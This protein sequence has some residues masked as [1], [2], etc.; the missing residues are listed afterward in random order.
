MSRAESHVEPAS[1]PHESGPHERSIPRQVWRWSWRIVVILLGLVILAVGG[2]LIFLHTDSGRRVLRDQVNAQLDKM[3]VGGAHVGEIEGSPFST[4]IARDIVIND[5]TGKPFATVKKAEIEIGLYPLI[6]MHA[7]LRRVSL[8]DV[9]V[10]V[11]RGADGEFLATKL[12][13][14][15]DKKSSWNIDLS[16]LEVI[17]GHVAIEAGTSGPDHWVNLDGLGITARAHI[18]ADGPLDATVGLV[19]SWRE[20]VAPIQLQATVHDSAEGTTI[21]SLI[22]LV[23]GVSVAAGNLSILPAEPTPGHPSPLPRISGSITVSAPVL[24]LKQLIPSVEL[25]DDVLVTVTAQ[26][27]APWTRLAVVGTL[28]TQPIQLYASADFA[29]MHAIGTVMANGVDVTRWSQGTVVGTGGAVVSFDAALGREGE[30]P[31]ATGL[32][33]AWGDVMN[34]PHSMVAATY[35]TDF[36]HISTLAGVAGGVNDRGDL[37]NAA[38]AADVTLGDTIMLDRSTLVASTSNPVAASGGRAPVRGMFNARLTAHGRLFPSPDLAV[39]G[40]ADG[41]NVRFQDMSA[42][43][44]KVVLDAKGLTS[45]PSGKTEINI[46]KLVRGDMKL[47]QLRVTAGSQPD[48]T[49]LVSVRS[50]PNAAKWAIDVDSRVTPPKPRTE[51]WV[52]DILNHRVKAGDMG[53]WKGTTGHL[54]IASG[55][56]AIESFQTSSARGSLTLTASLLPHHLDVDAD[57]SRP[58]IGNAHVTIDI[59]APTQFTNQVAWMRLGRS[60]IRSGTVTVVGDLGKAAELMGKKGQFAGRVTG[61]IQLSPTETTGALALQGISTP[62]LRGAGPLDASLTISQSAP[63]EITALLAGQVTGVGPV[64]AKV[65]VATPKDLFSPIAWA[66]LGPN[67]MRGAQVVV[68]DVAI[69]PGLLDKFGVTSDLRATVSVAANIGQGMRS[70]TATVDLKQLRGDPIALPIDARVEVA[71]DDKGTTTGM[72]ITSGNVTLLDA[73]GELPLSIDQVFTNPALFLTTPF[74][75][76][77]TVPDAPAKNFLAVFGRTE[78]ISGTLGGTITAEGTIGAPTVKAMLA[79]Q[80]LQ[81]PPGMNGRAV[82]MLDT[83]SLDASYAAGKVHATIT[84]KE[85]NGSL[86]IVATMDPRDLG[87]GKAT[88]TAKSFDLEPVL[89]FAPGALGAGRGQLDANLV[90]TG[91]DPTKTRVIGDLHLKKARVPLSPQIGTLRKATIDITVDEKQMKISAE[92]KLGGKESQVKLVGTI[93]MEGTLP[94]GGEAQLTIRQVRLI[95][96]VEPMID[97]DVTAKVHRQANRWVADLQV[98]HGNVKVPD[99]RSDPLKPIGIPADIVYAQTGE[100]M[101]QNHL[102]QAQ[103]QQAMIEINIDLG[104]TNVE[105]K[106]L[107][108]VIKGKVRISA[109]TNAV[110]IVGLIQAERGDLDLFGRRYEIDRADVR[111]DGSTDPLLDLAIVH[112]F[113][114][115]STTAVVR[116]RLSKPQLLLSSDPGIYSQDQLLG[117]LLGGEPNGDPSAGSASSVASSAGGS[118]IA[119]AIGGYVRKA[120]PIDIDVI[121]YSSDSGSESAAVTVGTWLT[122]SLFLAYR[123]HLAARPDENTNQVNAEYWLSHRVTVEVSTGDRGVSGIDLLWRK[124]Y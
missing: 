55:R 42:A 85:A 95:G 65:Q 67:A 8:T 62:A 70:A 94:T 81:A 99:E 47:G 12:M 63:D 98:R 119:N 71:I 76:K 26:D 10:R 108:G 84:G 54:E 58:E 5:P 111:F 28:G 30:K 101:E 25:P 29:A 68:S 89:L 103:P 34:L 121:R 13:V 82:K 32:A 92:G 107:R 23:G 9:D 116:G 93:G 105:S 69:E 11:A 18:P 46:E 56:I 7:A 104:R 77:A 41:S 4:L 19:G 24:A 83:L 57:I 6:G 51:S 106:E 16:K 14:P 124:R 64:Q 102:D 40:T 74:K 44:V 35:Q 39:A 86:E 112:D 38:V 75:V 49:I 88:I 117:F 43:S 90:V 97:A 22:A 114:D 53:E 15:N 110:G 115:V 36:K 72:T 45:A 3:F 2:A 120:L 109:D 17:N 79:I 96:A 91:F 118:F 1:A 100:K 80:K 20:R 123:V 21:P 27:A 52:V 122:K 78:V 31:V 61:R 48:K 87:N 33:M 60:A 37:L 50:R 113:S 59:D 66:A 73:K